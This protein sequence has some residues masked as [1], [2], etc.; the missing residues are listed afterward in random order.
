MLGCSAYFPPEMAR[1]EL[2]KHAGSACLTS[3]D[4]KE[5]EPVKASVQFEM[6]YFGCLVYQLCTEDGA[7]LW[8]ANQAD[9][10]DDRQMRELAFQWNEIKSA[11]LAKITWPDAAHLASLLLHEDAAW[12]PKTWDVIM[13]HPFLAPECG[14]SRKRIVMSCPE[15][16][17]LNEDGS[18]PYDQNVMEKVSQLQQIGYV[19]LGFDRA[20]TSTARAQDGALFDKAFSLR[21]AG[22]HDEATEMLKSTDWWYGYQTSVKQAVKLECQ[23]FDGVLNVTCIQGGFIT[24]LEA[25]EME[26]IMID[27][28]G[29]C[30]KS[31]IEVR[32]N[33]TE[34]S[35]YEFLTEY[36]LVANAHDR[37]FPERQHEQHFE[38]SF[39]EELDLDCHSIISATA[40]LG[41]A[42]DA[43]G[44]HAHMQ[45]VD[46][47]PQLE[48][49]A[50]EHPAKRKQIVA[51]RKD[52]VAH[53]RE[54]RAVL[55]T[56]D[57]KDK[58]HVA[59]MET[60]TKELLVKDELEHIA[61]SREGN[62]A[63]QRLKSEAA[64]NGQHIALEIYPAQ[65]NVTQTVEE[66]DA[67]I[68]QLR[69]EVAVAKAHLER[70][71]DG[72][73]PRDSLREP[74]AE[75]VKEQVPVEPGDGA[76]DR[77]GDDDKIAMGPYF[78][79]DV[80]Q[81][82]VPDGV[83]VCHKEKSLSDSDFFAVFGSDKSTFAK[84]PKWKQEN[85]KKQ[86]NLF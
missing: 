33:I 78:S 29:D 52:D 8:H 22:K 40:Q 43:Q 3:S 37:S 10:I 19:K 25:A 72:V 6:W 51:K 46:A 74:Q 26:R 24:Q 16:G 64:T 13:Q 35:Y 21:D 54:F 44:S 36:E 49:M 67:E 80:L 11:K 27:A 20:G 62:V 84:L 7:T 68:A 2:A 50:K 86:H 58:E 38:D 60:M 63:Q 75:L 69:V 70:I 34:V 4:H 65:A 15:L 83:D 30:A 41:E 81:S 9:N 53:N 39:N 61:T 47:R 57:P 18:G 14:I 1:Q 45:L 55:A 17:T 31:N 48:A 12:R 28:K 76:E 42:I 59:E 73:S 82:G 79:L 32:Y 71:R 66:K 5:L 23:N 85:L 56:K 77:C